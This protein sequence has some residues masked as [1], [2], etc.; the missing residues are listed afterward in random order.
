[1]LTYPSCH[2]PFQQCHRNV[3][4]NI[5]KRI[6]I[7][8][9]AV[10]IVVVWQSNRERTDPCGIELED[11]ARSGSNWP[12]LLMNTRER[13]RR[14]KKARKTKARDPDVNTNEIDLK[15]EEIEEVESFEEDMASLRMDAVGTGSVIGSGQQHVDVT[16]VSDLCRILRLATRCGVQRLDLLRSFFSPLY[17][18][19]QYFLF[20]TIS[21]IAN[22]MQIK[23]STINQFRVEPSS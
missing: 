3:Y 14:R 23:S 13:K 15:S 16:K 10:L 22:A 2:S 6:V 5:P 12:A 4:Q 7:V 1:M 18:L 19:C 9:I 11:G 21:L 20:L 8:I 17:F